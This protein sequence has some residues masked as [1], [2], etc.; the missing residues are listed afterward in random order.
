MMVDVGIVEHDLAAAAQRAAPVGLAFH[1][2]V[3]DAP[4]EVLGA[5]ALRQVEA[6]IADRSVDAFHIERILHH[7][8]TDSVTPAGTRLVA[9]HRPDAPAA[10]PLRGTR[11]PGGR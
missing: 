11:L 4:A 5:R 1:E 2:A 8:V 7:G 10:R 3:D 6:G 9:D